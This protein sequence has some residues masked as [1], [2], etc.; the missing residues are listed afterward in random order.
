MPL[1]I[2]SNVLGGVNQIRAK[3]LAFLQQF[4]GLDVSPLLP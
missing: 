3:L 4:A 1:N 2:E